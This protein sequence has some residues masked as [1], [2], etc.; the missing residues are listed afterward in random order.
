M[1]ISNGIEVWI[2]YVIIDE[3]ISNNSILE[4]H[5]PDFNE[6]KE[7]LRKLSNKDEASKLQKEA[8]TKREKAEKAAADKA[9]VERIFPIIKKQNEY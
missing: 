2:K 6:A 4:L 3:K 1:A 5:I 9:E 7:T 8:E